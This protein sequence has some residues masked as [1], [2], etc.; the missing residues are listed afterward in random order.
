M[1]DPS[2]WAG[3]GLDENGEPDIRNNAERER[4][5]LIETIKGLHTRGICHGDGEQ[6][7][8]CHLPEDCEGSLE[9]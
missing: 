3:M 9:Y 5:A 1:K 6:H 2:F 7:C 8:C 4:D